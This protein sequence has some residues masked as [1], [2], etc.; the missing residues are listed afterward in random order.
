MKLLCK[1]EHKYGGVIH[2][3]LGNVYEITELKH[4]MYH[5]YTKT[6]TGDNMPFSLNKKWY[7]IWDYFIHPAELRDKRINEILEDD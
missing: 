5:F 2:L 3:I 7:Y 4:T 1:K 6:E